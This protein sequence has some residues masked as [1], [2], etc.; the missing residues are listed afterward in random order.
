MAC[1]VRKRNAQGYRV[2]SWTDKT[3]TLCTNPK[4]VKA[5]AKKAAA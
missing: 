4:C 1:T 5:A 2:C 3:K